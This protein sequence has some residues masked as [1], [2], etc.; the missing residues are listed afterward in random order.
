MIDLSRHLN[1][2]E[3]DLQNK[4]AYVDGGAIWE[5]VEKVVIQHGLVTVAGM[6]HHVCCILLFYLS[7]C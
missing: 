7:F 6:V 4:L 3:I 2:V 1:T 5:Q